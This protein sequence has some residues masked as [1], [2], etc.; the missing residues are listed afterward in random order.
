MIDVQTTTTFTDWLGSLRD[1]K[2]RA[3]SSA[4]SSACATACWGM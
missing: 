2:A 3:I 1:R 4:G